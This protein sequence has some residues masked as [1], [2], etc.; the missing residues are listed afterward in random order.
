MP[1][2]AAKAFNF[3]V[4]DRPFETTQ[5]RLTGLQIKSLAGVEGS[6]ELFLEAHGK[7]SD[8]RIGDGDVVEFDDKGKERF[9]TAPPATYGRP[10]STGA[11]DAA[12]ERPV[13][14]DDG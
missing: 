14:R 1:Q 4:D 3:T 10:L 11:S 5:S 12:P 2:N 8:R 13:N 9:Y 6:L 7:G